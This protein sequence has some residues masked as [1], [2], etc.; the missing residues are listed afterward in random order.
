MELRSLG[1]DEHFNDAF[2]TYA[3]V[4]LIP[5]RVLL[6]YNHIF[7]VATHDG[8]LHAQCSGRLRHMATAAS[9][10]T[11]PQLPATGDWVALQASGYATALIHAVL[12]RRSAFLRKAAGR[13]TREQVLA[14]NIDTALLMVGLD[15]D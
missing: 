9:G 7:T 4:G 14:A 13:V 15:N 12:P 1:F 2:Q 10:S 5:G 11:T 3:R 8:E 6:Q